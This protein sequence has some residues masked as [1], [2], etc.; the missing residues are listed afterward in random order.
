MVGFVRERTSEKSCNWC[1]CDEYGLF[2]YLLILCCMSYQYIND[3][4]Y[5]LSFQQYIDFLFHTL[6]DLFVMQ[7]KFLFTEGKCLRFRI[8]LKK[9][10]GKTVN[11]MRSVADHG[12]YVCCCCCLSSVFQAYISETV[13]EYIVS[14]KT[15]VGALMC[16]RDVMKLRQAT[17]ENEKKKKLKRTQTEFRWSFWII[18]S[19]VVQLSWFLVQNQIKNIF[20]EN[21][22]QDVCLSVC[23]SPV[24]FFVHLCLL[25]PAFSPS[26]SCTSVDA[27]WAV[28]SFL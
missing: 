1:K 14:P 13:W 12:K 25:L 28:H 5:V 10:L 9:F 2:E 15:C 16:I 6:H 11:K 22:E 20:G 8:K 24:S 27:D 17:T 7:S 18:K 4:F 26:F 19:S 3:W 23:L 21:S